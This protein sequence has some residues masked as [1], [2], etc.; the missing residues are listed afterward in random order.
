MRE[1]T[2]EIAHPEFRRIDAHF[3]RRYFDQPFDN[4]SRFRPA[5]AAIGIDRRGVGVD[6]V[7]LTIDRGDVVLAR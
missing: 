7:D 5:G 6:A 2:D 3:T 1:G 4:E